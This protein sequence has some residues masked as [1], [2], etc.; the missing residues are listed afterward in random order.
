MKGQPGDNLIFSRI[1]GHSEIPRSHKWQETHECWVCEKY[2]YSVMIISKSIADSFFIK[3]S[4]RDR[5]LFMNKITNAKEKRDN[6]LE[7][8]DDCQY[9]SDDDELYYDA[10]TEDQ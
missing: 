2:R 10:D 1:L 4:Q 5:E 9:G 7:N 3:P 6:I 8:N